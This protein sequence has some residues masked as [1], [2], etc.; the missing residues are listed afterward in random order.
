MLGEI[1]ICQSA[2]GTEKIAGLGFG[3]RDLYLG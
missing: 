1:V 3:R 2:Q